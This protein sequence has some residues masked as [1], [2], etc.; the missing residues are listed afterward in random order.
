MQRQRSD[1]LQLFPDL[2]TVKR[3]RIN[4]PCLNTGILNQ[5]EQGIITLYRTASEKKSISRTVPVQKEVLT[6][7]IQY[8]RM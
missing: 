1:I 2:I 5:C 3:C 6:A 7:Q 8:I 4:S